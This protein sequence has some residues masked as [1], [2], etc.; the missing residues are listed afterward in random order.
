MICFLGQGAGLPLLTGAPANL[1]SPIPSLSWQPWTCFLRAVNKADVW[2]KKLSWVS[3]SYA[4]KPVLLYSSSLFELFFFFPWKTGVCDIGILLL[5]CSW[6]WKGTGFF[7]STDFLLFSWRSEK[8][9]EATFRKNI[10]LF[11]PLSGKDQKPLVTLLIS[12]LITLSWA[13][14]L[15]LFWVLR[16]RTAL[17]LWLLSG[18]HFCGNCFSVLFYE[19]ASF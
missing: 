5:F 15:S 19:Y 1:S 13:H 10:V 18:T 2:R 4:L 11:N 3:F 12:Q 16:I 6:Y 8:G 17:L 14:L 7:H 9:Y